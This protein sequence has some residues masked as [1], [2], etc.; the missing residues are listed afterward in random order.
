MGEGP[1][2]QQQ[3]NG[4]GNGMMTTG[5]SARANGLELDIRITDP[6]KLERSLKTQRSEAGGDAFTDSHASEKGDAK[7][8]KP[9]PGALDRQQDVD[10]LVGPSSVPLP[11]P[12]F[13]YQHH[14]STLA[15]AP[16]SACHQIRESRETTKCSSSCSA[17]PEGHPVTSSLN[18]GERFCCCHSNSTEANRRV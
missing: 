3:Q 2:Q 11:G 16:T 17:S 7:G 13:Q 8:P 18:G 1:Q 10:E 4:N 15:P 6:V 14:L 12:Q 5:C 9:A